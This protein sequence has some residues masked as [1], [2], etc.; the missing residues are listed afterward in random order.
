MRK[1]VLYFLPLIAI[2]IFALSSCILGKD[3]NKTS[4]GGS[5]ICVHCLLYQNGVAIVD[6]GADHCFDSS[7]ASFWKTNMES[8]GYTCHYE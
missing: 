4:G 2:V 5:N 1:K 8:G 7:G 3:D 6:S